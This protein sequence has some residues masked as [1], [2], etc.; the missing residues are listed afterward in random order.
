M[1]QKIAGKII[2]VNYKTNLILKVG[3]EPKEKIFHDI[4]WF[5]DLSRLNR[6]QFQL[7]TPPNWSKVTSARVELTFAIHWK[8]L[9][10]RNHNFH[11]EFNNK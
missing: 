3:G 5:V 1:N 4:Y 8:Q 2:N 6:L 7:N 9:V 11:Y 10:Q